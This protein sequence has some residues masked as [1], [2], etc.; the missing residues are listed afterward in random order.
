MKDP[1][2][3]A[4]ARNEDSLKLCVGSPLVAQHKADPNVR[5]LHADDPGLWPGEA[6]AGRSLSKSSRARKK[7]PSASN[8]ESD[9]YDADTDHDFGEYDSDDDSIH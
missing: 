9:G 8:S 7:I 6:R 2:Y 1:K 3:D 4:R 5:L